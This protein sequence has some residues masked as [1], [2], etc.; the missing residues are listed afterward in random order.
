[1][2]EAIAWAPAAGGGDLS[3]GGAVAPAAGGGGCVFGNAPA[4][5]LT[6]VAVTEKFGAVYNK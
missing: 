2:L 6:V 1:L 3:F 4:P 5:R